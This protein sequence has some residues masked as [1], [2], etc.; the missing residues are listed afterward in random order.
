[1]GFNITNMFNKNFCH[2][3][4]LNMKDTDPLKVIFRFLQ[5]INCIKTRLNFMTFN[6]T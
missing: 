6:H 2:N 5:T 4:V 3:I 1:M